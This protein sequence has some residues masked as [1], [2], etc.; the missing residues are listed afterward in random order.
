ME[1]CFNLQQKFLTFMS[2]F[3]LANWCWRVSA[4]DLAQKAIYLA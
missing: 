2:K 3:N 4:L 1:N